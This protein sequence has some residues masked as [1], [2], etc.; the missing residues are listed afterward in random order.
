[1]PEIANKGLERHA[2]GCDTREDW[3]SSPGPIYPSP[4][5]P[6]LALTKTDALLALMAL[7]WGVNI[8]VLKAAFAVLQPMALNA[9]RFSVA[10]VALLL[11][12]RA[13]GHSIPSREYWTRIV[14]L[15]VLGNTVYQLGFIEGLARTRAGNAALFMA[16]NPVFTAVLAHW[17]GHERLT[18]RDWAGL[19]CS[20]LGVACIVYG[21]GQEIALGATIKGDLMIVGGMLCWAI[22]SVGSRSLMAEIGPTPTA[23]WTMAIG[24]VPMLFL[25][26]PSVSSQSWSA[27]TPAAWGAVAYA[28]FLALVVAYLIWARGVRDV[29]ATRVALYS[30]ATPV[31]AFLAAWVFLSEIPTP[32]QIAGGAA[33]FA[34]M[35]LT[36]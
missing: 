26:I 32:F 8:I 19:A 33:V 22:Y 4:A 9:L 18:W 28:C 31:F 17:S 6:R 24:I 36:R 34:G 25:A 2:L 20:C 14:V 29:G 21:S 23:A 16:T 5:V 11:V 3:T 35:Y 30:N 10:S 15:G 12:A 7:I 13:M 27:V 1:M